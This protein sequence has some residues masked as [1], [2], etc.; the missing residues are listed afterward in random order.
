MLTIAWRNIWRNGR[1]TA[2]CITAVG[3]AVFFIIF[4]QSWIVGVMRG[5]EQIVRTYETGHVSAVSAKYEADR[6]YLPVQFPL[7][8]GKSAEEMIKE[9]KKIPGVKEALPRITV[10]GSL[11]DSNVKHALM[12]G[13]DIE[14]ETAINDF[15]LTKKTDGISQGRYPRPGENECAIGYKMAEKAGLTIGDT[16]TVKMVSSQFSDKYWSPVITGIFEFD[17]QKFDEDTIIVPI[18]RLQKILGLDDA[19][20]QLVVYA[21]NTKDSDSIRKEMTKILGKDTVVRIW[22]DNYWVAMFR[23]MSGMYTII[24]AVFQIVA[25]FLI[26]N[27]MLMIIHE[28]IKEIGMMGALGMSRSEIVS[29]FFLEALLLSILGAAAGSIIGGAG[30]YIGSLFPIDMQMMTGGGMKDFPISGTL[31]LAFSAD[32]IAMGFL[33]GVIISGLC[34]LIPSM[35]SAFI[36]PVE[37]LRR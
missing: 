16:V 30:S 1:R 20:Q 32:I 10:Y 28:R 7:A 9:I 26:I 5:V 3:I 31:Y 19:T 14:R 17:Y 8:D 24:F 15:N 33:F 22:S 25:S 36:E 13:I 12:W 35:K 6:E 18:D 34:T 37:A 2:L 27:T 21:D 11:F 23:S 29:V 4:M